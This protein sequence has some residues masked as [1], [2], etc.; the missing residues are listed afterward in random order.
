MMK[1][2]MM[3]LRTV[4]ALAVALFAG[5]TPQASPQERVARGATAPTTQIATPPRLSI[6]LGAGASFA[7][8][9]LGPAA[10]LS[11]DGAV[12][13]FVAQKAAGEKPQLYVRRLDQLRDIAL[14]G[15]AGADSPFFSPDGK[16]IAFFADG[17]LKRTSLGGGDP[18]TICNVGS[19]D[20]NARGGS[21]AED[22]TIFFAPAPRAALLRVPSSGGP[23]TPLTTLETAT[24]EVTQRWPQ[25]L[26]GGK[27]VM[28]TASSQTGD[29]EDANIVVQSLPGG[30][31]KIVQRDGYFGRYIGSGHLAYMHGGTL[32]VAPFD[33]TRLEMTGKP[34]AALDGVA[35]M[36]A[37]GG[38][39]FAFSGRGDLAFVPGKDPGL[40]VPI[41]WMDRH[42]AMRSMR[43]VP[44]FYNHPRFSPDGRLLA[45]EIREGR[46]VDVWV[47]E[48]ERD[49][50]SRLTVEGGDNRYPEWTPDGRRIAF[51]STRGENATRNLYWQRADGT[52]E[53]EQLARSKNAQVPMSWHPTGRA[54]AYGEQHPERGSDIMILPL[55][56]NEASGWKTGTPTVFLATPFDEAGAAFSPDGRWLAYHSN[57]SGR[58]EVYVRPFAG[59]GEKT[60]VS[61]GGGMYPTWSR[62]GKEL[63]YQQAAD[64][65][66][67]VATYTTEGDSFRVEKPQQAGRIPRRGM[68]MPGFDLHPDGQRF[69]VLKAAQEPTEVRQ[70]HVVLIPH[71]IDEVRR[72]AR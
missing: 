28:F 16:W 10:I 27:A 35:G 58:L 31:R 30:P 25:A 71:F 68:G 1:N 45:M 36:S 41:Q 56:G 55:L 42:G 15:T 43:A 12:I 7:A 19:A 48:W 8:N 65:T 17:K 29:F 2:R 34:V 64:W 39:H 4:A 44:A 5:A 52:G 70:N 13:V 59:S 66:L 62:N 9:A 54:L 24:G 14:P 6:E 32:F 50:I 67:M 61:T 33:L 3:W 20:G 69:A 26:L 63:F 60:Q 22:G 49:K 40:T 53:A 51:A 38:A 21:W 18:I 11:P 72:I 57:E 37:F 46:Q 23:P 47:Y